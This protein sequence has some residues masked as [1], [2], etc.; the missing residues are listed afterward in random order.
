MNLYERYVNGETKTVYY[1]IYSLGT[2]AFSPKYIKEVDK[3]LTETFERV[4]FNLEIIYKELLNIGYVFKKDYKFNF[5]KPIHKPLENTEFFLK[6]LDNAVSPFGFVPLSL[7]YFYKFVGGVNF[8]WDLDTNDNIM[9][10]MADPICIASLDSVIEQVTHKYWLEDIQYYVDDEDI[11][12]AFLDLAPDD[13]LKDGTSG[14]QPYAIE[15][16]KTKTIDSRFLNEP[17]DT[18]FIEYL[19]ICFDNC[20]FPSIT[21]KDTN[22][23]YKAF[24]DKV[25]PQLKKI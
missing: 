14:G 21:R 23:D 1:D 19:R 13:L 5:E 6:E 15:I 10:N 20:G 3:V 12:C 16:T 18:S 22:N 9:W 4:A 8:V 11:G 25:K 2:L 7:K 17:N 24:F